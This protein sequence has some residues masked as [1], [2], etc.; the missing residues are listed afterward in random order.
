MSE[1]RRMLAEQRKLD[2]LRQRI[3]Q[4]SYL[5]ASQ[6]RV[7]LNM[8]RATLSAVPREVLPWVPGNG[9][10]RSERRYHPSDVAAYPARAR[11]WWDAQ[12]G[13]TEAEVLATMRAELDER[14]QSLI[15]DALQGHEAA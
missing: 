11:R 2:A 8:S 13:G 6:V 1:E 5:K 15:A 12:A 4:T 10:E 3:V 14:D 7:H 9:H